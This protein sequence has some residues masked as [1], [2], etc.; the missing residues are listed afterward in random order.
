M[1]PLE[2]IYPTGPRVQTA[3]V[4]GSVYRETVPSLPSR[5]EA[6]QFV[7]GANWFAIADQ[8]YNLAETFVSASVRS[9]VE[10]EKQLFD[11]IKAEGQKKIRDAMISG[12]ADA[13][14]SAYEDMGRKFG[15]LVNVNNVTDPKE[16]PED[17]IYRR[18]LFVD[19]LETMADSRVYLNKFRSDTEDASVRE[20]KMREDAAVSLKFHS[21][22]RKL[23][24]AS[25]PAEV[26]AIRAEMENE[27]LAL[28]GGITDIDTL[29]RTV[30][31]ERLRQ[32]SI[33]TDA[34]D[35]TSVNGELA[36]ERMQ[37]IEEKRINTELYKR[38]NATSNYY[39]AKIKSIRESNLSIEQKDRLSAQAVMDWNT[40]LGELWQMVPSVDAVYSTADGNT[41]S[42]APKTGQTFSAMMPDLEN[43][44]NPA[45][46]EMASRFQKRLMAASDQNSRLAIEAQSAMLKK[47]NADYD[48]FMNGLDNGITLANTPEELIALKE[49]MDQTATF[50]NERWTFNVPKQQDKD[51]NPIGDPITVNPEY[52]LENQQQLP[53]DTDNTEFARRVQMR[54]DLTRK[55]MEK[56]R[57]VHGD[58]EDA[59]KWI[60]GRYTDGSFDTVR[61]QIAPEEEKFIQSLPKDITGEE[62]AKQIK[63][64][65][66][67]S[68]GIWT[69]PLM[70]LA[71][72][73][74]ISLSS[75]LELDK[76]LEIMQG[77]SNL[78]TS[79]RGDPRTANLAGSEVSGLIS[80]LLHSDNPSDKLKGLIVL[81]SL[82]RQVRDSM[83]LS[84]SDG[85]TQLAL[86]IMHEKMQSQYYNPD[87][88][89]QETFEIIQAGEDSYKAKES[90]VTSVVTAITN[91]ALARTDPNG[92][93]LKLFI[94]DPIRETVNK[95]LEDTGLQKIP[96][97]P[98]LSSVLTE[99]AFMPLGRSM[100]Q[101]DL[102]KDVSRVY[103]G[104]Y[105]R[106]IGSGL[107]SQA[108]KTV[109]MQQSYEYTKA[110]MQNS[111]WDSETQT[112]YKR[113]GPRINLK[114]LTMNSAT[115]Q[116][117][118][119]QAKPPEPQEPLYVP[120]SRGITFGRMSP[121]EL[122]FGPNKPP[123]PP[124]LIQQDY[125]VN[126]EDL[127]GDINPNKLSEAMNKMP[128]VEKIMEEIIPTQGILESIRDGTHADLAFT[129]LA[130]ETA[131]PDS[132]R[133]LSAYS[134]DSGYP[135]Q[136]E[137]LNDVLNI[138][139]GPREN[140]WG[141]PKDGSTMK[142][143]LM[144]AAIMQETRHI[145]GR[146]PD[147]RGT[148]IQA[149]NAAREKLVKSTRYALVDS[150]NTGK[151]VLAL[152]DAKNHILAE[153]PMHDS[154]VINT[155]RVN[156]RE[157]LIE[158][159]WIQEGNYEI[160][161]PEQKVKFTLWFLKPGEQL[162]IN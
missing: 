92:L 118:L 22:E 97:D 90:R 135:N 81:K 89:A 83:K 72:K 36:K 149:A 82:P 157:G 17:N 86:D 103:L 8:L 57:K 15:S 133:T 142:D 32:I 43:S 127:A 101:L 38:S 155:S 102:V 107:S 30:P 58:M 31:I 122:T 159:K 152:V 131:M 27:Y 7:K 73:Y 139:K 123:K 64:K 110:L 69:I 35:R 54:N 137:M 84:T 119:K 41:L 147:S 25:T 26:D 68:L 42:V 130:I 113:V 55:F 109:A 37:K 5:D 48:S 46:A 120:T 143:V 67:S 117:I 6:V 14:E 154:L 85:R 104:I 11:T 158:R 39:E 53:Y 125:P 49:Q 100:G 10:S 153:V 160:L 12:D 162:G 156:T 99:G 52:T 23:K 150:P 112:Y 121:T 44:Y 95:A 50:G 141:S 129:K 75:P 29:V 138:A 77:G 151:S 3:A 106:S 98:R 80:E 62:M 70:P 60:S 140:Y 18:R 136:Y 51:G 40:E 144:A 146:V 161:T 45:V 111:V 93:N 88:I 16:L 13:A 66:G 128:E 19:G 4:S 74:M 132:D 34:I 105:D 71:T 56:V 116:N 28:T 61:K 145:L 65:Y 63:E 96:M 126:P 9:S 115:S 2:Q 114:N 108:A 94:T 20:Q 124:T 33:A 87:T 59:K 148:L 78:V 91:P 47:S 21:L 1:N 79:D 24:G 76:S 134:K